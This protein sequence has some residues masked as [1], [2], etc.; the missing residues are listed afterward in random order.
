MYDVRYDVPSCVVHATETLVYAQP[1]HA[2]QLFLKHTLERAEWNG[3][4]LN[5]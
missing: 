2:I 1:A 4:G 5:W 3:V